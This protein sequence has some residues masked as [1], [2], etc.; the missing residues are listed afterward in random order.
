[1]VAVA[2]LPSGNKG[3]STQTDQGETEGI[4]STTKKFWRFYKRFWM[5]GDLFWYRYIFWQ[6]VDILVQTL[7]LFEKGGWSIGNSTLPTGSRSE[8][9]TQATLITLDLLLAPITL[10]LNNRVLAVM[11]EVVIDFGFAAGHLVVAGRITNP[12]S[13]YP[14]HY[15]TFVSFLAS[16][17]PTAYSLLHI[18]GVENYLVNISKHPELAESEKI[19]AKKAAVL[20]CLTWLAGIGLY[21]YTI[22]RQY[23]HNCNSEIPLFD[24]ECKLAVYPLVGSPACDCRMLV[25]YSGEGCIYTDVARLE[26]YHRVE[27][28]TANKHISRSASY[29]CENET[30]MVENTISSYKNLIVLGYH[31]KTSDTLGVRSLPKLEVLMIP[32]INVRYLPND[33]H[34]R[35]PEIRAIK[36]ESSDILEL[37]YESLKQLKHLEYVSLMGTAICRDESSL[38]AWT[39]GIFDCGDTSGDST[40]TDG[41]CVFTE[42]YVNSIHQSIAEY[43]SKWDEAANPTDCLPICT[44][45]FASQYP[46][47]D[48]DSSTTLDNQEVAQLLTTFGYLQPTD[49]LEPAFIECILDSCSYNRTLGYLPPQL[50]ALVYTLG[51]TD[52]SDCGF[53]FFQGHM[54]N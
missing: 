31:M 41:R 4:M 24:E 8:I 36:L 30:E 17:I 13:W 26:K 45:V 28:L 19:P 53:S 42:A 35:F 40:L 21:S 52:C 5:A 49:V 11:L 44:V 2:P 54:N 22:N 6:S 46:T 16:F 37:P 47:F 50:V 34:I 48:A 7:R 23:G 33:F 20:S 29:V 14:L 25:F 12:N 15:H 10:I 1:M 43:C 9:M 38:P 3:E 39:Q 32:F 18:V 27:Y 51:D